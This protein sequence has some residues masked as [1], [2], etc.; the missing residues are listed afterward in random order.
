[1]SNNCTVAGC[2]S[3]VR[4]RGWCQRH[5]LRWL[6]YGNPLAMKLERNGGNHNP[7]YHTWVSMKARCL[8]QKNR[9]YPRYGGRGIAV[10]E[11]WE[12]SFAAF[13][14][15]MGGRPTSK[16]QIDRI[17]NTKG[18]YKDNCRWVTPKENSR[19]RRNNKIRL[20]DAEKIRSSYPK[21][22]VRDMM[23]KYRL[24]RTM[25]YNIIHRKAW[26]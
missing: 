10:C 21:V 18:Y 26:A 13:Y 5:Y 14:R 12:R 25:V 24:S 3:P 17:D 19:N 6:K 1:M 23:K 20:E 16:H 9:S 7:L 8:N 22:T 2:G 15:D 4:T 11:E